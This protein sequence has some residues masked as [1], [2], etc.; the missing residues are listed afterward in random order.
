V[1]E[2]PYMSDGPSAEVATV[3]FIRA[4]TFYLGWV[5]V[6]VY[7]NAEFAMK[8]RVE[9]YATLHLE[10]GRYVIG[11]GKD[12]WFR[13]PGN[14]PAVKQYRGTVIF[15]PG[16]TYSLLLYSEQI[17][18]G[19]YPYPPMWTRFDTIDIDEAS[20]RMSSYEFIPLNAD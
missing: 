17:G 10:P 8:L 1:V 6:P 18:Y 19:A 11:V 9:T 16:E 5:A 4:D 20:K 12:P 15:S 3:N 13:T 7:L 2:N 14:E